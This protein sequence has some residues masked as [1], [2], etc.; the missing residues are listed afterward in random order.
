M[1]VEAA[2]VLPRVGTL[3]EGPAFHPYLRGQDNLRRLDAYD[4]ATDPATSG[5]RIAAALERVGPGAAAH[6]RTSA[7]TPSA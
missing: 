6:A 2:R 3:V 5:A 4:A 7:A 1:P